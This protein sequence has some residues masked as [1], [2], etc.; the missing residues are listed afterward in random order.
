[1]LGVNLPAATHA[2]LLWHAYRRF[3]ELVGLKRF[4]TGRSGMQ[5]LVFRPRL[6]APE[7]R[8][9]RALAHSGPRQVLDGAWGVWLL[10][11]TGD[12]QD[13]EQNGS[14]SIRS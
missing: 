1:L 6:R 2:A 9:Q 5:V 7:G 4:G 14:V 10:V 3:R 13:V 11:K 12:W 8:H